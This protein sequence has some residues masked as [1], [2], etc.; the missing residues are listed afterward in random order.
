MLE[1]CRE[2]GATAWPLPEAPG[3]AVEIECV[4]PG[5]RIER[6]IHVCRS[7]GDLRR[8]LGY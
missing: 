3:V 4:G 5:L 2:H 1:A 7:W 6:E 8:A